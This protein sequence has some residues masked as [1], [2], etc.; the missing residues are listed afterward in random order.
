MRPIPAPTIQNDMRVGA[1]IMAI[2]STIHPA[3][4]HDN[5]RFGPIRSTILPIT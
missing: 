3:I 5:A 4:T 2:S 1:A